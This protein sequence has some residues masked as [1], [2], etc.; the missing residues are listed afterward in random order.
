MCEVRFAITLNRDDGLPPRGDHAQTPE[1]EPG[2]HALLAVPHYEGA[3][4]V[5][6]VRTVVGEILHKAQKIAGTLDTGEV[7]ATAR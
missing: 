2:A 7:T 6:N 1:A 4:Y 5:K 3:G